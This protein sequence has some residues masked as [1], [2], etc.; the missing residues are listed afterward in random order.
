MKRIIVIFFASLC[1]LSCSKKNDDV[2]SQIDVL[3]NLIANS[4]EGSWLI[5]TSPNGKK[6]TLTGQYVTFSSGQLME[7]SFYRVLSVP[8]SKGGFNFRVSFPK[9][10]IGKA[11]D[12]WYSI[13]ELNI[14]RLLLEET[15]YLK[16]PYAELDF[17]SS[18]FFSSKNATG[19][20]EL[21][22]NHKYGS[23]ELSLFGE[24][25]IKVEGRDNNFY[26]LKGF[27]WKK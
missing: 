24:V 3:N 7:Q 19:S 20:V 6:D 15:F 17:S 22:N 5:M 12:T 23:S 9:T 10:M 4:N 13:H 14:E 16:T 1:I 25:I 11:D 2:V 18:T 8:T 26:D 27:I 21:K